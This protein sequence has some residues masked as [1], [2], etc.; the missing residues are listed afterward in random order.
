MQLVVKRLLLV[1]AVGGLGLL[2][3]LAYADPVGQ[4][5]NSLFLGVGVVVAVIIL[6]GFLL[7]VILSVTLSRAPDIV[8]YLLAFLTLGWG[9]LTYACFNWL[10]NPFRY[11]MGLNQAYGPPSEWH[12]TTS[13]WFWADAG[14]ALLGLAI[15]WYKWHR[16]YQELQRIADIEAS[17]R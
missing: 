3:Q 11:S 1:L 10:L 15:A 7:G 9:L 12:P 13:A 17:L 8:A 6:A 14:C 16:R 5:L 4:G 2:P